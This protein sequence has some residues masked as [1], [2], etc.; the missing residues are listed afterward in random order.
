M[1][2]Y[3]GIL[4]CIGRQRCFDVRTHLHILQTSELDERKKTLQIH[5]RVLKDHLG[6]L[7]RMKTDEARKEKLMAAISELEI[8]TLIYH[9]NHSRRSAAASLRC[10]RHGS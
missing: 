6:T 8:H 7:N 9:A 5:R 2:N 4:S 1:T 10:D 3:Q